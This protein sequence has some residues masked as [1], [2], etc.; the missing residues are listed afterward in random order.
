MPTAPNIATGHT[1]LPCRN[2]RAATIDSLWRKQ[3]LLTF[4][5]P[6]LLLLFLSFLYRDKYHVRSINSCPDSV[7]YTI[8][9]RHIVE[10]YT[11]PPR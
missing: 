9:Y 5:P 11:L 4:T 7:S 6:Y 3:D 1:I 8:L 10:V 2:G